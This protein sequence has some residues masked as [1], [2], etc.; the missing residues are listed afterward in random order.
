MRVGVVGCGS[1]GLRALNEWLKLPP[2]LPS[3]GSVDEVSF[4]DPNPSAADKAFAAFDV[5]GFPSLGQMLP[6]VDAVHICSP[7]PL[8]YEQAREALAAGKHVLVE[9]PMTLSSDGARNLYSLA[10]HK[11][12][13]LQVGHIYRYH[14]GIRRFAESAR[15]AL[16]SQGMIRYR[17]RWT[18]QHQAPPWADILWDLLPHPLDIL[19]TFS[20]SWPDSI[21]AS[22]DPGGRRARAACS[23]PRETVAVV[24][25]AWDDPVRRRTVEMEQTWRTLSMDCAG[26]TILHRARD[27]PAYGPIENR[28][29]QPKN[30]ALHD[31]LADFIGRARVG[32]FDYTSAVDGI[33]C[34]RAIQRAER[35][36]EEVAAVA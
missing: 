21:V 29:P 3:P 8:H 15:D 35:H 24:E 26:D 33:A 32:T 16:R 19:H 4:V 7:N 27:R 11:G 23:M 12:V 20:G 22:I 6:E 9:K 13:A 36:V 10:R 14:A 31:E 1:W 34:V 17:M 5:R 2:E 28:I 30:N 18:A 25:M